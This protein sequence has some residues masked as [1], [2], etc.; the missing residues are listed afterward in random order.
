MAGDRAEDGAAERDTLAEKRSQ[1]RVSIRIE[2]ELNASDPCLGHVDV[3]ASLRHADRRRE[4]QVEARLLLVVPGILAETRRTV[5]RVPGERAL[6]TYRV[7]FIVQTGNDRLRSDDQR[8]D[9]PN[10]RKHVSRS[11]ADVW[12]PPIR[13]DK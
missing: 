4:I 12:Q 10:Q 9:E 7:L 8:D 13:T 3:V 11:P 1:S 6:D 2:H 5:E